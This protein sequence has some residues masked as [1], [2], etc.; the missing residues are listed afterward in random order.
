MQDY[1]YDRVNSL[2]SH[3]AARQEIARKM[4]AFEA[5]HGPVET[6]P[7]LTTDKRIP[8]RISCPEKKQQQ[9]SVMQ[10][11][12]RSRKKLNEERIK[13]AA[14]NRERIKALSNCKLSIKAIAERTGLSVS[15]VQRAVRDIRN[16]Q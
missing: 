9:L 6:T 7:I 15:L 11:K 5:E 16:E 10:T 4:A 14:S 13:I 8:Y 3:E 12:E 1:R 2:A